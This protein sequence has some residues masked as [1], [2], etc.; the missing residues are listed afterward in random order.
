MSKALAL[1]KL[2]SIRD[3]EAIAR[4]RQQAELVSEIA[5]LQEIILEKGLVLGGS[6][7]KG[8]DRTRQEEEEEEDRRMARGPVWYRD[9]V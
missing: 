8:E 6:P 3:K 4:E 1:E 7:C 5:A 2:L 9:Q